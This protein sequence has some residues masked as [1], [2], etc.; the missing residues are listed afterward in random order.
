MWWWI[1][2]ADEWWDCA[3]LLWPNTFPADVTKAFEA[4][5]IPQLFYTD[6]QLSFVQKSLATY[7]C[8]SGIIGEASCEDKT[9]YF[10]SEKNVIQS[11]FYLDHFVLLRRLYL[12]WDT[13]VC[14]E[15]DFACKT[16][17]D[18]EKGFPWKPLCFR[19]GASADP[20]CED[21]FDIKVGV[22][23]GLAS[24]DI[25]SPWEVW[26][27]YEKVRSN[28]QS[29]VVPSPEEALTLGPE[30]VSIFQMGYYMCNEV[31]EIFDNV[32]TLENENSKS[33]L[34]VA[35]STFQKCEQKM[36][37][38]YT[39][40]GLEYTSLLSKAAWVHQ[41]K[42]INTQIRDHMADILDT[43]T[44]DF[45]KIKSGFSEFMRTFPEYTRECS[46]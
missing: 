27:A 18:L 12:R 30:D 44:R 25:I 14:D 41:T 10:E 21:V 7:C 26:W 40:H 36:I 39:L 32:L 8:R 42:K 9:L 15:Y 22:D 13:I 37:E 5:W 16:R 45:V 46:I 38:Y 2:F 34:G 31:Q 3:E 20:A 6:D 11:P 33:L 43:L 19:Q 29:L 4:K 24:T 1:A 23:E 35:W 17:L 28:N